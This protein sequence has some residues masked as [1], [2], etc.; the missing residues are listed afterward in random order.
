MREK[1]NIDEAIQEMSEA[2]MM[3][4]NANLI[5]TCGL[6]ITITNYTFSWVVSSM[7]TFLAC[8]KLFYFGCGM[9]VSMLKMKER[10]KKDVENF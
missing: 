8:P 2:D 9:C 3:F 4:T 5:C 6:S 1:L 10:Y 7:L